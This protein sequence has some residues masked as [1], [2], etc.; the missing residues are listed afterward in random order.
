MYVWL[1][2]YWLGALAWGFDGCVRLWK[3]EVLYGVASLLAGLS[4]VFMAAVQGAFIT[5][6]RSSDEEG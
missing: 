1:A 3:G 5:L 2:I 4:F 6:N